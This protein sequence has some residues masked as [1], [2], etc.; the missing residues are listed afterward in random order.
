MNENATI[1]STDIVRRVIVEEE[2]ILVSFHG[3]DGYFK[4][5]DN[6]NREELKTCLVESNEQNKEI[7][8]VYDKELSILQIK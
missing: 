3:H 2:N 4:I 6:E 5:P 7:C 8:F 1:E